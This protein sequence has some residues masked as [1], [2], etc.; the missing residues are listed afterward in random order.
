[1]IPNLN[2]IFI[3]LRLVIVPVL[4]IV[5]LALIIIV[6]GLLRKLQRHRSLQQSPQYHPGATSM[7]PDQLQRLR[8]LQQSPQAAYPHQT[9]TPPEPDGRESVVRTSSQSNTTEPSS[10]PTP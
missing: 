10:L 5:I 4:I 1:M 3:L 9:H 7:N 2:H 6:V 8:P